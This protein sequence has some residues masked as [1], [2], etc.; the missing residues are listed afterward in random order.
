MVPIKLRKLPV[1]SLKCTLFWSKQAKH[2]QSTVDARVFSQCLFYLAYKLYIYLPE[3]WTSQ[4]LALEYSMKRHWNYA[5]HSI[6][7]IYAGWWSSK[8]ASRT[9]YISR[10]LLQ[11][12]LWP[13]SICAMD[14]IHI[15]AGTELYF[16]KVLLHTNI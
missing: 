16:Q 3:N 1:L 9:Y 13:T 6:L 2:L 5:H 4:I 11:V 10:G 12:L 7:F 15:W 8:Y 14:K